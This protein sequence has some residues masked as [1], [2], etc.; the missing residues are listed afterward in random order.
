MA[1]FA[2][3]FTAGFVFGCFRVL[4]VRTIVDLGETVPN[5]RIVSPVATEGL[6][7]PLTDRSQ[8]EISNEPV[9]DLRSFEQEQVAG[10]RDRVELGV[11]QDL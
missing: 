7:F 3:V 10:A 2:L 4:N 11:R 5:L 8:E 6:L 9:G 1:Y